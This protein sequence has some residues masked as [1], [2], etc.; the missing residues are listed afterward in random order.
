MKRCRHGTPAECQAA[1]RRPAEVFDLMAVHGPCADRD[2]SRLVRVDL[3]L[4]P[5]PTPP[6]APAGP[7]EPGWRPR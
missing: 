1:T 3:E 4:R 7:A 6:A 5:G 2:A